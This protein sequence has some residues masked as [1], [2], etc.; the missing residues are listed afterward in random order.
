MKTTSNDKLHSSCKCSDGCTDTEEDHT[1]LDNQQPSQGC[2]HHCSY[3]VS[4]VCTASVTFIKKQVVRLRKLWS[5]RMNVRCIEIEREQNGTTNDGSGQG[6]S[7]GV[8]PE[9][10]HAFNK[11]CPVLNGPLSKRSYQPRIFPCTPLPSTTKVTNKMPSPNCIR[12]KCT[13]TTP[14]EALTSHTKNILVRDI[15]HLPKQLLRNKPFLRWSLIQLHRRCSY[16]VYCA[17][18]STAKEAPPLVRTY[19]TSNHQSNPEKNVPNRN[20]IK[21]SFRAIIVCCHVCM[22][23]CLSRG[24]NDD[25]HQRLIYQD[26][27]TKYIS[28]SVNTCTK[29]LPKMWLDIRQQVAKD[30]GCAYDSVSILSDVQFLDFTSPVDCIVHHH[31]RI[32]LR[33]RMVDTQGRLIHERKEYVSISARVSVVVQGL[34]LSMYKNTQN[35]STPTK[36]KNGRTPNHHFPLWNIP[37]V[38]RSPVDTT[39]RYVT[40]FV[41][42]QPCTAHKLTEISTLLPGDLFTL[43]VYTAF[44]WQ[45]MK[46][47]YDEWLSVLSWRYGKPSC[48]RMECM[49]QY[50]FHHNYEHVPC[51]ELVPHMTFFQQTMLR[52]SVRQL[53]TANRMCRLH[54]K[55]QLAGWVQGHS[56]EVSYQLWDDKAYATPFHRSTRLP[57][58]L[59][60][61]VMIKNVLR[62]RHERLRK[63]KTHIISV[64][65]NRLL[66]ERA[67]YIDVLFRL[68]VMSSVWKYVV[69]D[70]SIHT[71][72]PNSRV[73]YGWNGWTQRLSV[74]CL[75]MK[76]KSLKSLGWATARC[77]AI[78]DEIKPYIHC[79]YERQPLPSVYRSIR[80]SIQSHNIPHRTTHNQ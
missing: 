40:P 26:A 31:S 24:G 4:N 25:P 20:P 66:T 13:T 72:L 67:M 59:K 50:M 7:S 41:H 12:R 5:K 60:G 28:V 11:P 55:G 61:P 45:L 10:H 46:T 73:T 35:K 21:S 43:V 19:N 63:N 71:Q 34:I 53:G 69:R 33:V 78:H 1:N 38:P 52:Y 47:K 23:G 74:E 49:Y 77:K 27:V 29:M 8:V 57:N 48:E 42:T 32:P 56:K 3:I 80:E 39:I 16:K 76:L 44:E 37:T 58:V 51:V 18:T 70:V 17:S 75:F 64:C 30:F 36:R 62:L 65:T 79:P 68:N 9:G 15:P 22:G 54:D 14:E 6:S 2:L